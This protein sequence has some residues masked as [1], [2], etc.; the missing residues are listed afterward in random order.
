MD[1][2]TTHGRTDGMNVQKKDGYLYRWTDRRMARQ[3]EE[4]MKYTDRQPK[5]EWISGTMNGK[6]EKNSWID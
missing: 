4:W 6:M 5:N 3:M 2:Q 1:G